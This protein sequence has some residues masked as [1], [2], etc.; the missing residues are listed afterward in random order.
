MTTAAPQREQPAALFGSAAASAARRARA[1][2]KRNV[3]FSGESLR[4]VISA[5]HAADGVHI[6][7]MTVVELL[8]AMPG[9]GPQRAEELA[10]RAG[11]APSRR[12]GGLGQVQVQ[13]LARL[14]D[15]RA[16]RRARRHQ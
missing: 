9:V 3:A 8:A 14:I 15:E 13:T 5:C 10:A 2:V 12:L 6:R 16:V 7:R 11:I 4:A 1:E